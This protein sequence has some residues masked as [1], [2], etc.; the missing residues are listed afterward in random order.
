MT[1]PLNGRNFTF[2]AQ[3]GAGVNTPQADTRGNAASGA[4]SANGL[5]PAQNNYL[6]GRYRQQLQ[7]RR[8]PEWNQLYRSASGGRDP[9]V[10]SSDRGLQRRTR[11]FRRRGLNATI[12]SGTNSLH[13]AAWEFF[14][15]DMLDAAD[16]FSNNNGNEKASFARIN[17]A[18]P[19]A[20]R[21]SRTRSSS[22]VT[23]KG[24]G[25]CKATPVSCY[26]SNQRRA[27]QRLQQ[28]FGPTSDSKTRRMPSVESFRSGTVLDPATTRPVR[29]AADP[30]SGL[31]AIGDLAMSAIPSALAATTVFTLPAAT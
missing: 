28:S 4:F 11:P 17:S 7:C 23:M 27:H 20:V 6:L 13:G 18:P 30:V 12:K 15:N 16:W 9:G 14:R 2:L 24:C 29:Q 10:Q 19:S 5:R 21:S 3:L 8:L 26:R 31:V 22:S 1:C 25:A